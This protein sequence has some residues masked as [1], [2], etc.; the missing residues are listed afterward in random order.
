MVIVT[1]GS[2]INRQFFTVSISR[3]RDM[4][5][6]KAR[7][8]ILTDHPEDRNSRVDGNSNG[9]IAKQILKF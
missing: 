2:K 4:S 7:N 9:N 1:L 6:Y 8:S 3:M 5:R